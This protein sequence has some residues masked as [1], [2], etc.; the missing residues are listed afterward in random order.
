MKKMEFAKYYNA[1][2]ILNE[3]LKEDG[4][5][6]SYTDSPFEGVYVCMDT[7]DFWISR[8]LKGYNSDY[9][10][11]E[12]SYVVERNKIDKYDLLEFIQQD[13]EDKL[14]INNR[15]TRDDVIKAFEPKDLIKYVIMYDDN[16]GLSNWDFATPQL[17][18]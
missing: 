9:E 13:E 1:T 2:I 14:E 15:S 17:T 11:D 10:K 8:I 6:F 16:E 18:Q 3:L 12:N 5:L 7:H 4:K